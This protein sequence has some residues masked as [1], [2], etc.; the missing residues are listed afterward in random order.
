MHSLPIFV[1][2][3]GRPVMLIG[4]GDTAEAKR[5]LLLRAGA[6]I[7]GEDASAQLAIVVAD[8]EA[9]AEAVVARLRARAILVNAV[10][11]PA[12]C[13]FTLPAIV[14]RDPV[15]I[16]IGTGGRSAG[17]AK[18][19]RQRLETLLPAG[20]GALADAL[21]AA[22]GRI[23]ARWPGPAERRRAIDSA[24]HPGG[25]AD[26]LRPDADGQ[27]E[28]WLA[29]DDGAIADRLV[30][31]R[32]RSADPDD[33]T[34]G[35]ARLLGQADTLYHRADIPGAILDRARADATRVCCAAPPDDRPGGLSI[36]VD[37]E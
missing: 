5:R 33:L 30:S 20:L 7:V 36:D 1:D 28:H 6:E 23:R 21:Y 13:D 16:A 15:L 29:A 19:L 27:I 3:N 24:L 10:D 37:Y 2:L 32:L 9:E 4:A 26:P 14:D 18:E 12:L 35:E 22:R 17:L 8:D 31:I 34:L 25:V 11:R